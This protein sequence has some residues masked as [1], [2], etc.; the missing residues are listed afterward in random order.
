LLPGLTLIGVFSVLAVAVGNLLIRVGARR[1]AVPPV[2]FVDAPPQLLRE[3]PGTMPPRVR[4][5]PKVRRPRNLRKHLRPGVTLWLFLVPLG[6]YV[7]VAAILVLRYGSIQGDAQSRVA[8]AWYVWF[9][10][11]P[12]LAAIGFVWNPLPSVLVMPFFPFK[13][14]WPALTE[15]AFAGNIA[16]AVFMA[17]CV[18][19][20]RAVFREL[21]V[22]RGVTW[23]L[24]IAFALNP[25]IVYYGANGMTEAFYMFFLLLGTRFLVRWMRR[26]DMR[27]LVWSGC[28]FGFGY[29]VRYESA[30]AAL[31]AG[32]AIGLIVFLQTKGRWKTRA[33]A[34]AADT[35][36]F[37]LPP[38]AAFIGW[39]VLSYVITGH[40]FD[41]FS[42][43]YGISSQIATVGASKLSRPLPVHEAL[44]VFSFAPL[45]PIVAVLAIGLALSR[46][47]LKLV[48][49]A[50]LAGTMG[51]TYL[52]ALV[53]GSGAL[54]RYFLPMVPLGFLLVGYALKS[55]ES[56][57]GLRPVEAGAA[58]MAMA[59]AL[60]IGCLT[61]ATTAWA[62][63]DR[64]IGS[65]DHMHL[66]W[67]LRGH[68]V[69]N[70]ERSDK[71][72]VPSWKAIAADIDR[73]NFPSGS[74]VTDTFSPCISGMLMNSKHPH[75]FVI[76]SDR[77]FQRVLADPITFH[78]RYLIVPPRGGFGD[79]DAVNRAYPGLYAN[80]RD[81]TLVTQYHEPG[82][83]AFRLYKLNKSF[84]P[85]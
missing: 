9:S 50:G 52:F 78:A 35:L 17:G 77:D 66:A 1:G 58:T 19:Q 74:V 85:A 69:N 13:D 42:S 41:Q 51:F 63:T 31:A 32:T 62:L 16:S 56:T 82:C 59:V 20:L 70:L 61:A 47:D 23:A 49:L 7:A 34:A 39:A 24:V 33:Q 27:S 8:D 67:V 14:L 55:L 76:T 84:S 68:P 25:M 2:A 26:R 40:L 36:V 53:G 6:L 54:Y 46:R 83:P 38:A 37:A 44:E 48:G 79:L 21:K 65:T 5:A 81:S 29:L 71:A 43:Q 64:D 22:Q 11:D 18:V 12:H 60:A 10:R 30:F 4:V 45:L 80:G 28:A 75:Q 72:L 57:S 73:R 15:R 3:A